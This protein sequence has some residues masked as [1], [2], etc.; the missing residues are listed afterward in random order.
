[1]KVTI[2]KAKK[3]KIRYSIYIVIGI[4]TIFFL[5]FYLK[6]TI[7]KNYIFEIC[8]VIPYDHF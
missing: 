1:M 6:I 8:K 2:P 5:Y 7:L 3:M 4:Y